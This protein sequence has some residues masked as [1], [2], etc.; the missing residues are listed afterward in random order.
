MQHPVV[1]MYLQY[2]AV[3]SQHNNDEDDKD[4]D[5]DDDDNDDVMYD[6]DDCGG[7]NDEEDNQIEIEK[8][9]HWASKFTDEKQAIN[10][11]VG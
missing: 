7:D 10:N 3:K 9:D 2:L 8:F 4:E 11:S 6:D 1:E 5:A